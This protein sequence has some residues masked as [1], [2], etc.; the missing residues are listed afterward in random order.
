MGYTHRWSGPRTITPQA[1]KDINAII[2][3][4][5]VTIKGIAGEGE[6]EVNTMRVRLNGDADA[7]EDHEGFCVE[8]GGRDFCKTYGKPYDDVVG[9]ILLRI[10]EDSPQFIIGSD[11]NWSEWLPARRLFTA[12]MGTKP[13]RPF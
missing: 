11:G 9:A 5:Q 4:S 12:V 8:D 3:A 1:V 6:P 13:A 10:R 2:A 7:G